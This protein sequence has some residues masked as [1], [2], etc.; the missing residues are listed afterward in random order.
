MRIQK[1]PADLAN[2]IAAGEV[3]ERP[4]SV[5]KEL[6]ENA[7]DAQ[8]T[9]L[10]IEIGLGGLQCIKISDNGSGILAE[11][12]PLAIAA[13]ATSKIQQLNDLYTLRSMGFRGEALAS[14]ASVARVIIRSKPAHQT[15]AMVL[16]ATGN[17]F[18]VMPCARATGTT[19][20]VLDLFFN[21][22]VRKKFLTTER[23]E[24][25]AIEAIV[26]RFA[27]SA[28]YIA[29]SLQ[30]NGQ[31][32]LGLPAATC[33]KT[34]LLRIKKIL[35]K[36]FLDQA[37]AIDTLHAGMQLRGWIS[38]PE[39]QR[40]QNDK[41]WIYINNRMVKDKLLSH[42]IKQAYE[43]ILYPGR[44][45]S[46]LLY[47]DVDPS[48]VD[49]N[50]HPTKQEVRFQHPRYVHDF[51][52]SQLQAVVAVTEPEAT[53]AIPRMPESPMQLQECYIPQPV[54]VD[55]DRV[56]APFWALNASFAIAFIETQAYLVDIIKLHHA[57]LRSL[58]EQDVFPLASRP[59]LVPIVETLD[60]GKLHALEQYFGFCERLG[61]TLGQLGERSVRVTTVPQRLP[62]LQ[63]KPFLA[64][65]FALRDLDR[66]EPISLLLECQRINMKQLSPEESMEL[67]EFLVVNLRLG[68]TVQGFSLPLTAE[69]CGKI[70]HG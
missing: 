13:H 3:I 58:L 20:E 23:N 30:H 54:S 41:Q 18:T 61:V 52:R 32:V 28:P 43:G 64:R 70:M 12:L 48:E 59:L 27:L 5:V 24:Y 65:V 66:V 2:Q 7:Y 40:S 16:E 42:A 57:W 14:I 49:I 62:Q 15:D 9:N 63:I 35:G 26:K 34:R 55:K 11:D 53:K 69:A 46:C 51:I 47:L 25:L 60:L 17:A 4:A 22:P 68:C 36:G 6:L 38:S 19:V 39:Y 10:V 45:P 50:V 31:T 33:D 21:A 8:A 44:F 67:S 56:T 37:L 1:L 29:I